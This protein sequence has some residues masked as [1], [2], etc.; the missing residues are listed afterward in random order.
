MVAKGTLP[1]IK[2][3]PEGAFCCIPFGRGLECFVGEIDNRGGEIAFQEV[4]FETAVGVDS[5]ACGDQLLVVLEGD[6]FPVAIDN[7]VE[8]YSIDVDH[9]AAGLEVKH[10]RF[11]FHLAFVPVNI[12]NHEVGLVVGG[13]YAPGTVGGDGFTGQEGF[14]AFQGIDSFFLASACGQCDQDQ[15]EKGCS[16]HVTGYWGLDYC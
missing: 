12:L 14:V 9:C 16:F 11:V 4:D 8:G 5:Q 6:Q 2:K 15:G 3:A 13:L 10:V 1:I 7:A